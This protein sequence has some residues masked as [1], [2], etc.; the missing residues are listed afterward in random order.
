MPVNKEE[1]F[2]GLSLP[3]VDTQRKED[4]IEPGAK[5]KLIVD[6]EWFELI[7]DIEMD[8]YF[9]AFVSN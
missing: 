8:V 9:V 6:L 3:I 1:E 2:A 7:E 4:L 5:G